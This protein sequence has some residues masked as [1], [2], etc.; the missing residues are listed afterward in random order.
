MTA[1][2]GEDALVEQPAM[3]LLAELGWETLSG[4][5]EHPGSGGPIGRNN[6]T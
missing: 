3:S 4:F 2:Y 1:R 6:I 5:D